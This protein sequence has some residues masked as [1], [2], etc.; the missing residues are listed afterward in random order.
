ME[1]PQ[2]VCKLKPDT[3]AIFISSRIRLARNVAGEDF[4][5]ILSDEGK[6]E[7]FNRVC[8]ALSKVRKF[9]GG[10]FFDADALAGLNGQFLA[11]NN[12]L[13]RELL[14]A[15]GARGVYISKDASASVMIN[16]EDHLR[17]Q[18]LARG[19]C[20]E[21]LWKKIDALDDKIERDLPYAFSERYGYLTACPTNVGTGLRASVMMHLTGLVMTEDM[22]KV[23]RGLSQFGF[24][25]RGANGEGSEPVG[26][27]YQISNQQ[28]LGFREPEMVEKITNICAK[29][30]TFE[31]NAR[32]RILES[33]P[34][35][36]YDKIARARAIIDSCRMISSTEACECLSAMRLAADLGFMPAKSKLLT[37][38]LIFNLRPAHLKY[39]YG[40]G[41]AMTSMQ[42]DILR[43]DV[44][45]EAFK[46]VRK[47]SFPKSKRGKTRGGARASKK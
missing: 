29:I 3:E 27:F 40:Q 46:D 31:E 23:I 19:L 41:G 8:E 30:A 45:R 12:M 17:I 5:T 42:R 10:F 16:E 47:P 38:A 9:E 11:E 18:M 21:A 44:L 15:S 6:A 22:E 34:E 39:I 25:A 37:D 28:T 43:A 13:S 20:L 24:V 2:T 7:V 35:L 14:A 26:A 36:I 33:N 1:I 32:L 4:T